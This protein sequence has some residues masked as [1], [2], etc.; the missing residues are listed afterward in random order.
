MKP[1]AVTAFPSRS[2]HDAVLLRLKSDPGRTCPTGNAGG[3]PGDAIESLAGGGGT[4]KLTGTSVAA[5]FVS[6]AIALLLSDFPRATGAAVRAAVSQSTRRRT[7]V[8]PLLDAWV[9]Y[10]ALGGTYGHA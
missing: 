3:A 5:P 6:G 10:Q 8:P 1:V 2:D 9:A 7:I 4:Q